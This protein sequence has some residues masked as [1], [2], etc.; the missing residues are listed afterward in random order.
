MKGMRYTDNY[1]GGQI[2]G[3][4]LVSNTV[5]NFIGQAVPLFVGIV[6]IPFI[7]RGLGTEYFGI[8]CLVWAIVGYFSLFDLGLGRATTK[9]V[10]EALSKG[11][12]DQVPRLVWTVITVQAVLGLLGSLILAGITPLLVV[13]ILNIPPELVGEAK[14][15]FYLLALSIP[16]VLI[17]SSFSGMLEAAQRFDLVNAVRIPSSALTFLLPL[18]GLILGFELPGIVALILVARFG[19]LSALVALALRIFPKV[20]KFSAHFSLFPRLFSYGC[21]IT[22]S[23][24]VGPILVYLDRFLI[25]SLLSI[26]AVAY[27]SAPYEA[28]TRLWIIPASLVMSLFPAFSALEG[29]RDRQRLGTLFALS[30]KFELLTLGPIVTSAGAVC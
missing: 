23:S 10:A 24:V 25:T 4:L 28:V 20:R 17:S 22:V 6:T 5:L 8:L 14:T 18:I 7:I 1:K 15:T 21:W 27:Y 3:S 9:F 26:A 12:E 29:I 13:R 16:V 30:V 19:A 11:D 2:R